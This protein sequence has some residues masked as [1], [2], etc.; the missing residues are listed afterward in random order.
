MGLREDIRYV[1]DSLNYVNEMIEVHSALFKFW[2]EK[3]VDEHRKV[4]ETYFCDVAEEIK[5]QILS[6]ERHNIL[7]SQEETY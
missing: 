5:Q 4:A 3:A 6:S 1:Q 2:T 7:C